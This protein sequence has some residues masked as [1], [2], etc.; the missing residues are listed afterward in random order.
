MVAAEWN[1]VSLGD[2]PIQRWQHKIRHLHRFLK[3]W[4]KNLSGK[5]KLEKERLMA[6]IEELDIKAESIP[7]SNNEKRKLREANEGLCNLRRNE[8]TKWSQRAMVKHIQEGGNNTKYFHLIANGK[9]RKKKIFQLEQD[10][11]TIVGEENLKVYIT[12]F[13]KKLFGAPDINSFSLM[14]NRVEDIPRLS[15][16]E[17]VVLTAV[18]SEKEVFEAISQME[19]NKAPS[20]DGFPTE[21]YQTFWE[22]IKGDLMALFA[23]LHKGD[24]PLF[25]LNFGVITLL[26]KKRKCGAN[27]TI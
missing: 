18:F 17:N 24:M 27:S 6:I 7:L 19:H 26:P 1:A 15:Q 10:E 11:G 21:F 4:A 20:P 16:G 23:C 8:E 2:T 9:H 14:E 3:G 13:Y 5:Y 22:V 25:M 12:E